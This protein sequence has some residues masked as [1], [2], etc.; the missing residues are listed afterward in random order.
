MRLSRA[1]YALQPPESP[2]VQFSSW[3]DLL[4]P[5][6]RSKAQSSTPEHS[7]DPTPPD[8]RPVPAVSSDAFSNCPSEIASSRRSSTFSSHSPSSSFPPSAAGSAFALQSPS[9]ISTA[10]SS[11]IKWDSPRSPPTFLPHPPSGLPQPSLVGEDKL[12]LTLTV[13]NQYDAR[14]VSAIF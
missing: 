13:R 6:R 7:H 12:T 8:A 9:S 2:K 4:N 14:L 3:R 5:F 10:R 1:W 11:S